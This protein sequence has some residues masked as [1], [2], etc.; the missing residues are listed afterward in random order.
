MAGILIF[1][2]IFSYLFIFI[3]I[4]LQGKAAKAIFK[5]TQVDNYFDCLA[6]CI[7][8]TD[9]QSFNYQTNGN[10]KHLCELSKGFLLTSGCIDERPG[11]TYFYAIKVQIV[12]IYALVLMMMIM[13]MRVMV[14]NIVESFHLFKNA[15][16]K[17]QCNK[18]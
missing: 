2:L 13:M 4:S 14:M 1:F 18:A 17:P 6:N 5:T 9:C 3:F 7:S 11:Y 8:H 12:L 15:W 10:P 16:N